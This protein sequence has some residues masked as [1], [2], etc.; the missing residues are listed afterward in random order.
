MLWKNINFWRIATLA[1]FVAVL[2]L[3]YPLMK[4]GPKF[5]L[6]E[7]D[8]RVVETPSHGALFK[9]KVK[10]DG[11]SGGDTFVNFHVYLYERGGDSED[12]YVII[13]VNAGE[14]KEGEF[15]MPLRP[16]QTVHDWRVELT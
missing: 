10:N 12:D 13:G 8:M 6:E 1:L 2:A 15:F 14:T 3:A 7:S 9:Y 5:R 4:P 16:G 11:S